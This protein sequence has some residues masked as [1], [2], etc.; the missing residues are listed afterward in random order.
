[1]ATVYSTVRIHAGLYIT[2]DGA[3]KIRRV[4]NELRR[5][6]DWHVFVL[7]EGQ[8]VHAMTLR[9]LVGA[10]AYVENQYA[11]LGLQRLL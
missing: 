6:W 4:R 7:D 1:M 8:Y 11:A 2:G 10:R 5:R 9:T 3:F